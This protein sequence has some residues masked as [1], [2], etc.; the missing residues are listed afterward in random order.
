LWASELERSANHPGSA[1]AAT[2]PK[3]RMKSSPGI[4]HKF[5]DWNRGSGWLVAELVSVP[6]RHQQQIALFKGRGV[7]LPLQPQPA[8]ATLDDVKMRKLSGGKPRRP[9]RRQ[10][11]PT[12]DP[13][14]Q[15]E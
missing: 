3:H 15:L 14:P 2:M 13:S 8:A 7:G 12:E 10:L 4:A 1:T 5:T 6:A 9:R 11:T